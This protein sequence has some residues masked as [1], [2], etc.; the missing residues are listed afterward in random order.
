MAARI[1]DGRDQL[2]AERRFRTGLGGDEP[3]RLR[4]YVTGRPASSCTRNWSRRSTTGSPTTP[5]AADLVDFLALEGGPDAD[6]DDLVA[7]CQIGLR[8]SPS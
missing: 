6:F 2:P 7:L 5:T 8:G 1:T 4:A 3:A